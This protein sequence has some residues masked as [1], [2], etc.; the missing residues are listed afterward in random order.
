MQAAKTKPTA[1]PQANKEQDD[2]IAAMQ[3]EMQWMRAVLKR[4]VL[5]D[6]C[7]PTA[8][9]TE[10]P[11]EQLSSLRAELVK[12]KAK[13]KV[14]MHVPHAGGDDGHATVV[15]KSSRRNDG[16]TSESET[17]G[18]RRLKKRSRTSASEKRQTENLDP[19]QVGEDVRVYLR[20]RKSRAERYRSS[21]RGSPTT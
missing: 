20:R 8:S 9:K 3:S 13:L 15:H 6:E 10:T 2:Q 12:V 1:E 11:D 19:R 4:T 18:E 17:D 21:I 16:A 7:E 14:S 5:Q